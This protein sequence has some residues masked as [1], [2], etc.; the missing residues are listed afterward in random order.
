M[1]QEK[2]EPLMLAAAPLQVTEDEPDKASV[3]VP[4]TSTF[5]SAEEAPSAGEVTA[6]M[7]SV[8][9]IMRVTLVDA[10]SPAVSVAVPVIT[11]LAPSEQYNG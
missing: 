9:S 8:L 6:S 2:S 3:V 1:L 7:G 4:E 5:G 11:W 10:V